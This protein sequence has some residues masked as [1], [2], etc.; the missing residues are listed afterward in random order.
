MSLR[1]EGAPGTQSRFV[2]RHGCWRQGKTHLP[3]VSCSRC[4]LSP[5][6]TRDRFWNFGRSGEGEVQ[7]WVTPQPLPQP[8]ARDGGA[9]AQQ[10]FRSCS[11]IEECASFFLGGKGEATGK[12]AVV[13]EGG[14]WLLSAG[15]QCS[16]LSPPPSAKKG[17]AGLEGR[18]ISGT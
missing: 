7:N 9:D 3:W 15:T 6:D 4:R 14:P 8:G 18:A 13:Q 17:R 11:W 16:N 10:G 12:A 1:E 5:K 2:G